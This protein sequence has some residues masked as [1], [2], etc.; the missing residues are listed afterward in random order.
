RCP[1]PR[2]RAASGQE[3]RASRH[4]RIQRSTTWPLLLLPE[5]R[6]DSTGV[7]SRRRRFL[8]LSLRLTP[9]LLYPAQGECG[10]GAEDRP[11]AETFCGPPM[12]PAEGILRQLPLPGEVVGVYP[13]GGGQGGMARGPWGKIVVTV[14]PWR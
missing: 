12:A 13:P 8:A 2:G 11:S 6:V 10:A 5:P 9:Q 4:D 7:G 3:N 14:P 1:I